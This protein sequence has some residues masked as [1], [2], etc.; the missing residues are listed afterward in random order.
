MILWHSLFWDGADDSID[1]TN[2]GLTRLFSLTAIYESLYTN[3]RV[4]PNSSKYVSIV[5]E[6]EDA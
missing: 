6:T 4:L 1:V 2:D 3:N 5:E